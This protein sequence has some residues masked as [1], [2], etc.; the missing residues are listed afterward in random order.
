MRKERAALCE[1]EI[2][3]SE[4]CILAF[5]RHELRGALNQRDEVAGAVISRVFSKARKS[6]A[7][8][9][10]RCAVDEYP[11][12][13]EPHTPTLARLQCGGRVDASTEEESENP[14][15]PHGSVCYHIF[16]RMFRIACIG[17][18]GALVACSKEPPKGETKLAASASTSVPNAAALSAHHS[19]DHFTVDFTAPAS[20]KKGDACALHAKLVASAPFHINDEYPY[21]FIVDDN[22][23]LDALPAGRAFTKQNGNFKKVSE[24]VGDMEVSVKPKESTTVT[25]EFRLSICAEAKCQV[26]A[27]KLALPIGAQ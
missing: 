1:R 13:W 4:R 24:T 2:A 26:E 23:S 18:L 10:E 25:G 9:R 12:T 14:E 20:C 19:G 3:H 17:L 21:K 15:R 11:S 6:F 16:M 7:G 8:R 22:A 27:V 5:G